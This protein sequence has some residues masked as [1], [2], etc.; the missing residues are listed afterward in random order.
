M[1]RLRGAPARLGVA[2]ATTYAFFFAFSKWAFA[3][4]YFL[5]A[6]LA[7]LAAALA[8]HSPGASSTLQEPE[9]A[10]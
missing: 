1:W 10:P 9:P 5:M 3:T 7:A 8:C 2:L 4:Y 6:S